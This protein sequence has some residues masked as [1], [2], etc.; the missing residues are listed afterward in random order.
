MARSSA[1]ATLAGRRVSRRVYNFSAGPSTLPPSVI[2]RVSED[3]KRFGPSHGSLLELRF[4]GREFAALIESAESDLRELLDIPQR[5]AVLFLQGGATAQFSLLPL[6]LLGERTSATYVETGY[7]SRRAIDEARRYC[8]VE[9]LHAQ[10]PLT[11]HQVPPASAF[12]HIT[13]NE[14]AD[15]TAFRELPVLRKVPL[16][17]DASSDLLTRDMDV[18]AL[19]AI[20][21]S[22]QK[23]LGA[24][25]LAI[26]IIERGLLGRART[27]TPSVF[28]YT[29][30]A[31]A[32]SLLNTPATFSVY[33]VAQMLRWVSE[34][35]GV[36][37]ME[38]ASRR[39]SERLYA[40]ID[41]SGGFYA[42]R[43]APAMRSKINV[44]FTLRDE[45]LLGEFLAQ[46]EV[47]GFVN[48]AGHGKVGG[49]RASLYNAMPEQG[50]AGL[51][52]FMCDFA[53]RYG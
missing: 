25:G 35:G 20:Y 9:V 39:K 38:Q 28:D 47:E 1:E 24:T 44:C 23:N 53:R 42:A 8:R 36:A 21:A 4:T 32:G 31:Q 37:A 12:C 51:A 7:W 43:A 11:D 18:R 30:Q 19:G 13:S 2:E 29:R 34:H 10:T 45:A 17:V 46:A 52:D 49:V 15:G 5:Y 26:V 3:V 16:V 48:L 6:N 14:T 22:A 50:V 40:A 27:Q 33:V 41:S